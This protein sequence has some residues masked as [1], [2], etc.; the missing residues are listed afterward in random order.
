MGHNLLFE[1]NADFNRQ[2]KNKVSEVYQALPGVANP[3]EWDTGS[4]LL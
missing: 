1:Q 2:R 3:T 4:T